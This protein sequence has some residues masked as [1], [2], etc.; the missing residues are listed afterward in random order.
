MVES[1]IPLRLCL[2]RE[3]NLRRSLIAETGARCSQSQEDWIWTDRRAGNS[4]E[5][6]AIEM[7]AAE[8]Q[9]A[10]LSPM[11]LAIRDPL[12]D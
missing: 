9:A 4:G 11:G 12:V 2:P 7:A 5:R 1:I 10:K 8:P 3:C 6:K